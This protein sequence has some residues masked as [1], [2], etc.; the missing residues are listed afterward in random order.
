MTGPDLS[1][2]RTFLDPRFNWSCGFEPDGDQITCT[3]PARWH[4]VITDSG[5]IIVMMTCCDQH[6]SVMALSANWIHELA[7]VCFLPGSYFR[8]PENECFLPDSPVN[9]AA[10]EHGRVTA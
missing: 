8:W 10:V 3:E 2:I 9:A 4:G 5:E 7:S 1:R 6:R